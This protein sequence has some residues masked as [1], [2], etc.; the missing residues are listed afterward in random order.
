MI[1]MKPEEKMEFGQVKREVKNFS[2]SGN[3]MFKGPV[4]RESKVWPEYDW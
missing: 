1:E 2:D 4:V 3:S